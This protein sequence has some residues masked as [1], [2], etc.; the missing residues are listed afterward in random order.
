MISKKI[1][2]CL[3]EEIITLFMYKTKRNQT[4][5]VI[6]TPCYKIINKVDQNSQKS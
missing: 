4:N 2:M 6:K 3:R 5:K 1:M